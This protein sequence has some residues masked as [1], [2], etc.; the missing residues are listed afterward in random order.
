MAGFRSEWRTDFEFG[1]TYGIASDLY[2]PIHP[3][4]KWFVDPFVNASQ[5]TFLVYKESDPQAD[6]RVDRVFAGAD[7]GYAASRFSE[8]RA[9]YGI[10]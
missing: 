5:Y 10:G 7:I 9:G 8:V 1:Q 4:G 6:Y 3:L 2:R